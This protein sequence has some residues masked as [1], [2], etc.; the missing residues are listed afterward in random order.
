MARGLP[1]LGME[2]KGAQRESPGISPSGGE[3]KAGYRLLRGSKRLGHWPWPGRPPCCL[4]LEG[5]TL[6]HPSWI[7]ARKAGGA[8][9]QAGRHVPGEAAGKGHRSRL[10]L[11]EAVFKFSGWPILTHFKTA[12][13]VLSLRLSS[14]A[15][16]TLF[17]TGTLSNV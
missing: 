7:P 10:G 12:F 5:L 13:M 11:P 15:F 14:L 16:L 4:Y 2:G 1:L 9:G 6:P 17:Q 3:V 8:G